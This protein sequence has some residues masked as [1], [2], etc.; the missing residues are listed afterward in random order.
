VTQHVLVTGGAGFIGS[1]LCRLLLEGGH[2]VTAVDCFDGYYDPA[3]KRAALD[4]LQ[5][6]ERFALAELDVLRRGQLERAAAGVDAIAHLAARPGVRSSFAEPGVHVALNVGGTAAVLEAGA[7]A[8]VRRFVVAS[9]SSVYG[10]SVPPFREDAAPLRPLSPYGVSKRAAELVCAD[11]AQRLGVSVA[12]LRLFS[13]YGPRQRPDQALMRF[14]HRLADGGLLERYGNPRS[15]RDYTHVE[16]AARGILAA[17]EWTEHDSGACE[18]FNLG[19]GRPVELG[20]LIELLGTA[21]G[22]RP[23]VRP[24]PAQRG[25]ARVT[26]ADIGKARA[27]L[28]YHPQVAIEDGIAQFVT[29]HEDTYG[30]QSRAT[31]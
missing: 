10:E 18:T 25:D 22:R 24:R 16:D 26:H 13:V 20:E 3:L 11:A 7:L 1:Q 19:S 2:R 15:A 4:P 8:G 30:R 9:S 29:W 12:V 21:V 27:V 6:N 23:R 28:G 17:L 31:A 14:V 5:G